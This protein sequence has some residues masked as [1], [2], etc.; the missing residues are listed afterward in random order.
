[1][2]SKEALELWQQVEQLSL[3][4]RLWFQVELAS[5]IRRSIEGPKWAAEA[6]ADDHRGQVALFAPVKQR[7]VTLQEFR[8]MFLAATDCG[9][10]D[11]SVGQQLLGLGSFQQ[12][13]GSRLLTPPT[14]GQPVPQ[15]HFT[16]QTDKRLQ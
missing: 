6:A 4:D 16:A 7:Q 1:M 10:A 3:S 8:Q 13:H 2:M 12:R 9:R 14:N 11:N 5:S 15:L